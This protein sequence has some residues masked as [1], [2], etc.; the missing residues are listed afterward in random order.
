MWR[1]PNRRHGVSGVEVPGVGGGGLAE[2][3][4]V[5]AVGAAVA[6]LAGIPGRAG[7]EEGLD[8]CCLSFFF[9]FFR[10]VWYSSHFCFSSCFFGRELSR[11]FVVLT[12]C[13]R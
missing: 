11:R 12:R 5:V 3:V 1:V 9:F 2:G 8:A 6:L 13:C 10:E 7:F 4:G